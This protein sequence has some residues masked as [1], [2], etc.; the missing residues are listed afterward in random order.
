MKTF[1]QFLILK[2]LS[3]NTIEEYCIRERDFLK[4]CYEGIDQDTLDKYLIKKKNTI[5]ARGFLKNYI[6]YLEEITPPEQMIPLKIRKATGRKQTKETKYITKEQ[7]YTLVNKLYQRNN[8]KL[9]L[10]SILLFESGLRVS[11]VIK[12]RW[13]DLDLKNNRLKIRQGKGGKHRETIFSDNTK[14]M[15]KEYADSHEYNPEVI[16]HYRTV[17]E[18]ITPYEKTKSI[19]TRIQQQIK[20]AGEELLGIDLHPH[21]FRHGCGYYLTNELKLSL[22]EVAI[23]LGHSKIE[24]TRIYAHTEKERVLNKIK[25]E[26]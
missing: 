12:L 20:K 13:N 17:K 21:M 10:I 9:A 1:K 15:I 19:R 23:Y 24:T 7:V 5:A 8:H 2:N 6:E 16:F 26:I 18:N 25:K 4:N 22:E 11:E 14:E 3:L